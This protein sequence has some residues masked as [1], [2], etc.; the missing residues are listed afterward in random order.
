MWIKLGGKKFNQNSGKTPNNFSPKKFFFGK[1]TKILKSQTWVQY[2]NSIFHCNFFLNEKI[3][4]IHQTL[5]TW[6]LCKMGIFLFTENWVK[7]DKN[8]EK[9]HQIFK[10]QNW[11]ELGKSNF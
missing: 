7:G 6:K 8:L 10:L 5:E 1:L 3:G 11:K 2:K 9:F 4:K